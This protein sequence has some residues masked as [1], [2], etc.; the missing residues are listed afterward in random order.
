M[1]PPMFEVFL[2]KQILVLVEIRCRKCGRHRVLP[3]ESRLESV[4]C[5]RCG[6]TIVLRRLPVR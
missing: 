5:K 2:V 4:Q 1:V 6:H 3:R